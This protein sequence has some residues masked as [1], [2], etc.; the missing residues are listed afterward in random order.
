MTTNDDPAGVNPLNGKQVSLAVFRQHQDAE[1]I[2]HDGSLAGQPWRIV[3]YHNKACDKLGKHV[4]VVWHIWVINPARTPSSFRPGS[5]T[6]PT[7]VTILSSRL[8]P[9]SVFTSG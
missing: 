2:N 4:Q 7:S 5:R 3:N 8:A 9:W 1:L 6:G